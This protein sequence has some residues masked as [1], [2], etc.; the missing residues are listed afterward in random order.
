M[1][2]IGSYVV[3]RREGFRE[4]VRV[5]A[6]VR[7][8]AT[9]KWIFKKPVTR[10]RDEFNAAWTATLVEE[11]GFWICARRL[12]RRSRTVNGV[13]TGERERSAAA[14]TLNKLFAAAIPF[15]ETPA[16]FPAMEEQTL[17]ALA[18]ANTETTLIACIRRSK[19]RMNSAAAG[20]ARL[21][22]THVVTFVI[23]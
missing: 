1:S 17:R 9:G 5:A 18:R 14:L 10:G 20:L 4:C 2:A 15:E 12:S 22:E 21:S 11:V 19:P 16:P 8:E 7:T 13:R 23:R 6:D 3:L